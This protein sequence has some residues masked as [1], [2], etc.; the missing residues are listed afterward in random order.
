MSFR[1][2]AGLTMFWFVF[3]SMTFASTVSVNELEDK[4]SIRPY[5]LRTD[6]GDIILKFKL[7]EKSRLLIKILDLFGVESESLNSNNEYKDYNP[8]V[9]HSINLGKQECGTKLNLGI[10]GEDRSVKIERKIAKYPCTDSLIDEEVVFGF[11]TDTQSSMRRYGRMVDYIIQRKDFKKYSFIVNAGDIVNVGDKKRQWND[12]F[13]IGYPYISKV[14]LVAAIG[15]HSYMGYKNGPAI[16][17][18]FKK[19]LRWEGA[20]EFGG[21]SIK[22][23]QFNLIVFNSIME[24]LPKNLVEKQ[25]I[26][27]E[28]KLREA[29][30]S[31]KPTVFTMHYP[32]FSSWVFS[33][34][35]RAQLLRNKLVPLLEKYGVKLVLNGHTHFYERSHKNGVTYVTGGPAGGT[36][37][38]NVMGRK[39][40]YSVF[41]KFM[42][43]TLSEVRIDS[44]QIKFKTFNAKRDRLVDSF[45][46]DL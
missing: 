22:Y 14:P 42:V 20:E 19:Y 34:S 11:I 37:A 46:I 40:P 9:V 12:F 17:P 44:K 7:K 41:K 29:Q 31:G 21:V 2:L 1:L 16:T 23:P 25:W 8:K 39:N 13:N 27:V 35:A 38:I 30:E 36:L 26:W 5:T 28:K 24:K 15:N 32:P 4:Y 10:F 43:S 3:S 6:S 18:F 45:T 33:E